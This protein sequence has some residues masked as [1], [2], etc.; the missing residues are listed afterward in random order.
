MTS[1]DKYKLICLIEGDKSTFS[2]LISRDSEVNELR[3]LIH[4]EGQ[5]DRFDL[6]LLDLTV[7]KVCHGFLM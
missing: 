7:L 6:R 1:D 2:V 5:L 4:Q 3:R